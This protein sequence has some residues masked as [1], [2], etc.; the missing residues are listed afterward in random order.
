MPWNI[1]R[2]HSSV[3]FSIRH[4][5]ISKVRGRF[6]DFTGSLEV[7]GDAPTA[8]S[9]V[10]N[11]ASIDTAE[12]DRDAHL[13]SPDFFDVATFP[14]MTFTSS[15]ITSKGAGRWAM[16]GPLTLHGVT[17][18]VTFDVTGGG[19]AKDPW[20]NERVV[21]E[22]TTRINR[23]DFGLAWNAALETGGVLVGEDVEITLEVQAV[24]A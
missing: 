17:H 20:G 10:V 15:S 13:K 19:R 4:L 2:A 14:T 8:V 3:A 6:R 5:V 9:A 16:S 22:G 1:D 11:V 12:A 24:R 7:E 21:Y 23:K 18:E